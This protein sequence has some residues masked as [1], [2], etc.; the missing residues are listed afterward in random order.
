MDQQGVF[1][2]Q[3]ALRYTRARRTRALE[4]IPSP[5]RVPCIQRA[6]V[7]RRSGSSGRELV[8]HHVVSSVLQVHQVTDGVMHERIIGLPGGGQEN[9][10]EGLIGCVEGIGCLWKTRCELALEEIDGSRFVRDGTGVVPIRGGVT[11]AGLKLIVDAKRRDGNRAW[12][13]AIHPFGAP[14]A[15]GATIWGI[16]ITTLTAQDYG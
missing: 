16:G 4:R 14:Q 6:E 11:Q 12:G 10:P 2:P 5:R 15:A 1:D 8:N 7:I 9:V 3:I 13:R